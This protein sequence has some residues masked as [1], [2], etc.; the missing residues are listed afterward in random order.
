MV[1]MEL[2]KNII[3]L[4]LLANDTARGSDKTHCPDESLLCMY[5]ALLELIATFRL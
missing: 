4:G 3:N 2:K 5:D 1:T